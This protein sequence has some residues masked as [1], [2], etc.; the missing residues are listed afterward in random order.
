M[1]NLYVTSVLPLLMC[2][3]NSETTA[4]LPDTQQQYVVQNELDTPAITQRDKSQERV[5]SSNLY[6]KKIYQEQSYELNG[7]NE[8]AA[9]L[10]IP[11]MSE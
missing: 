1:A 4:S 10:P 8:I 5:T 11:P 7:A 9:L 3:I 6:L 2:I